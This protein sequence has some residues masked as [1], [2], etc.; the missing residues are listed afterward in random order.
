MIDGDDLDEE[1]YVSGVIVPL[2]RPIVIQLKFERGRQATL[3]GVPL[4]SDTN[5]ATPTRSSIRPTVPVP[6]LRTG[7]WKGETK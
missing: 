2:A 1:R 3:P 6:P 4:P 5:D 7:W